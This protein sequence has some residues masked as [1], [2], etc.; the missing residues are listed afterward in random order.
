MQK[1]AIWAGIIAAGAAVIGLAKKASAVIGLVYE[2]TNLKIEKLDLVNT[3]A[4]AGLSINNPSS[5]S[6]SF[7]DF[8][9]NVSYQGTHLAV[10]KIRQKVTI[11]ARDV[12]IL[13]FPLI[14]KT[15]NLLSIGIDLLKTRQLDNVRI[16]GSIK[17][18]GINYPVDQEISMI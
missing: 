11:P 17:L 1:I 10:V 2:F 18:G 14:L 8:F 13:Y 4:T 6:L 16:T 3:E 7:E 15:A 5:T 9:G 12:T